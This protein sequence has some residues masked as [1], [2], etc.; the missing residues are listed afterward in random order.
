MAKGRRVL[1]HGATS[2]ALVQAIARLIARALEV[3]LQ[4]VKHAPR[5]HHL[6][7]ADRPE[8]ARNT[9]IA[10]QAQQRVRVSTVTRI[11]I[12]AEHS[13]RVPAT[14]PSPTTV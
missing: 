10:R 9:D 12:S 5:Q 3:S 11:W 2:Y 7:G 13:A 6:D 8:R 1:I 4:L 14:A